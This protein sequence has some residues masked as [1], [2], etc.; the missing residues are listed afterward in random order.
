MLPQEVTQLIGKAGEV[1]I[2]EVEKGAIK[3]YADA[4]GDFNP[5]YWEDEYAR[6]SRFGTIT[7]PPGFFGW[8]TRWKTSM[9]FF[10]ELQK[11]LLDTISKAGYTRLLAGGIEFDFIQPVY[12]GDTLATLPRIIDIVERETKSGNMVFSTLETTYTNQ[13]GDLLARAR[14]TLIQR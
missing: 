2:M 13:N 6:E 11:E 8:P 4:I 7:A 12:A 5:L 14:N 9:P 10:S 1:I 3:K